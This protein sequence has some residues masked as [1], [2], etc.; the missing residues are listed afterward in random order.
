M[1]IKV[2]DDCGEFD[3]YYDEMKKYH[4][5]DFVG[6]IAMAY[7]IVETTLDLTTHDKTLNRQDF[8]F[9]TAIEGPG[10]I[11]GIEYLTRAITQK[12]Y[13]VQKDLNIKAPKA[14]DGYFTFKITHNKKTIYLTLKD[15]VFSDQFSLVATK[16]LNGTATK[17]EFT[18]W[19]DWKEGLELILTSSDYH[20][21]FDIEI[22]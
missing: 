4:G 15:W 8:F 17:D 12:R 3:L 7:K 11:D 9:T 6:G 22:A 20:K 13:T 21:V 10:I 16:C 5:N 14:P 2:K 19:T 18:Q 1:H